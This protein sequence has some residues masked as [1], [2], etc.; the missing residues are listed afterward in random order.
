MGDSV[1][2][3]LILIKAKKRVM[4]TTILKYDEI[5]EAARST[6]G[7][8]IG[9]ERANR[10]KSLL[11]ELLK[12]YS[13]ATGYPENEILIA[14]EKSRNVNCVN[15]YQRSRFPKLKDVHIYNTMD[16]FK[17]AFPSGRYICPFCGKTSSNPYRCT[18]Y[19]DKG[20]GYSIAG[21]FADMG[22]GI[23]VIIKS[24][25]LEHPVPENIFRPVEITE[26]ITTN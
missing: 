4:A 9:D 21:I 6:W 14:F 5:I 25:F 19:R 22:N 18:V 13:E 7:G 12:E 23:K 15:F 16:D 24:K 3:N 17:K 1:R 20:C 2:I 11:D 8:A 26:P 10:V